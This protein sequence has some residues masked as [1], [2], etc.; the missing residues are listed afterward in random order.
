[1]TMSRIKAANVKLKRAYDP[2]EA[3][4]GARILVDRLWPRGVKKTDAA[5]EQWAKDLA[6]SA[7][8]RKWFGHDPGRWE[9]FCERYAAEVS[10]HPDQLKQLRELA[11]ERPI[12]LIYSAYDELHNNAV[13]LRGLILG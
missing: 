2:P 13:A 11:R 7:A 9:E 10:Q 4:D 8:L 12:T 6:P 3:A 1:M 5:I